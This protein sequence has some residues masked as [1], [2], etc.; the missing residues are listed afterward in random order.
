VRDEPQQ[1]QNHGVELTGIADSNGGVPG[2]AARWGSQKNVHSNLRD[3]NEGSV[4]QNT[5]S[6]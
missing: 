3:L 2:D 1:E 4:F 6:A 5:P